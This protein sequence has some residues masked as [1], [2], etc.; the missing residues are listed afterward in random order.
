MVLWLPKKP[1]LVSLHNK[2]V[3]PCILRDVATKWFLTQQYQIVFLFFKVEDS[4][5]V[6]N[7]GKIRYYVNIRI[8]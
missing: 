7:I 6:V 4:S 3:K 1:I 2:P 8:N 5:P